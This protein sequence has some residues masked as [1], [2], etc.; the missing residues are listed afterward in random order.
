MVEAILSSIEIFNNFENILNQFSCVNLDQ[1]LV[2]MVQ[3]PNLTNALLIRSAEKKIEYVIHMKHVISLVDPLRKVLESCTGSCSIFG[4]Y[5][6]QLKDDDFHAIQDMI[7]QVINSNTQFSRGT[8]NMKLEK[9]FAIKDRF[10]ALLDLAR[11]IYSETIDDII[12]LVKT[13]GT[14]MCK[15]CYHPLFLYDLTFVVYLQ[16]P[17]SISM[18]LRFAILQ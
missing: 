14:S 18:E 1:L 10:N 7:D 5:V 9:C 3:L 2:N 6:E 15:Y 17:S 11:S 8:A 4:A 16:R 13:Y 12:A